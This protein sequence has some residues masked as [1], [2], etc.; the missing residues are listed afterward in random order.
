MPKGIRQ[1]GGSGRPRLSAESEQGE[2]PAVSRWVAS[3]ARRTTSRPGA[4]ARFPA[5]RG[6]DEVPPPDQDL[7]DVER[8]WWGRL[9]E[10]VSEAGTFLSRR[11]TPLFR[12]LVQS[13]ADIERPDS[14]SMACCGSASAPTAARRAAAALSPGSAA[15]RRPMATPDRERPLATEIEARCHSP[16]PRG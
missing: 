6:A 7:D 13:Y 5:R 12:L 10:A 9:A 1:P 8:Q 15:T 2:D 11:G 14:R 3:A 4:D 16:Q